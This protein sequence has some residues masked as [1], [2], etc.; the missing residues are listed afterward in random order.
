MWGEKEKRLQNELGNSGLYRGQS[1]VKECVCLESEFFIMWKRRHTCLPLEHVPG[2]IRYC[3]ILHINRLLTL[4]CLITI[5]GR[6]DMWRGSSSAGVINDTLA[7]KNMFCQRLSFRYYTT[8]VLWQHVQILEDILGVV[9]E[10][11]L[12]RRCSFSMLPP[13]LSCVLFGQ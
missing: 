3:G 12:V 4:V 6:Y 11:L 9:S 1:Q 13:G 7:K 10:I 5:H 8:C 2:V